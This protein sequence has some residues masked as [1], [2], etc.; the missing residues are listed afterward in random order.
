MSDKWASATAWIRFITGMTTST[1]AGSAR[2]T[3]PKP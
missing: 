2:R 3:P 1:A